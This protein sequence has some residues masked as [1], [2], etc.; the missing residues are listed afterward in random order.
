[1]PYRSYDHRL[2]RAIA[3]SGDPDLF[4]ELKIPRS[5]ARGWIRH[6]VPSV[7][8]AQDLD[9]DSQ[10]LLVRNRALERDCAIATQHLATFTFKL[11]GLQIQYRRLPRADDKSMLLSAVREATLVIGLTAALHAIGWSL[12]RFSAWVRRERGCELQDR[13]SCPRTIPTQ[14]TPRERQQI[15]RYARDPKLAHLSV[16]ALSWLAKR[17]GDVFASTTTWC[18]LAR[19]EKLRVPSERVYPRASR[20]GI[21]ADSP[22]QIWHIDLTILRLINGA[23]AF[24]QAVIDNASRYVLA[25]HVAD[26]Y[27]GLRTRTLL[28]RALAAAKDMGRLVISPTSFVIR[29]PRTSMRTWT[30]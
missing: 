23:R 29:E 7:V 25:F 8:T 19:D 13:Q 4:P 2:K 3:D 11:F 17:A 1:V 14:L 10:A 21:R 30:R 5:T 6:G 9:L 22:C 27:G 24:I 26:G 20:L 15:R 12:A 18:R 16:G 28:E